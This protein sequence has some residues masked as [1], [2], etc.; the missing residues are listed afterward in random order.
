REPD[1]PRTL[2]PL[3]LRLDPRRDVAAF[4]AQR[5]DR[6]GGK[7]VVP[8][9][10]LEP[11]IAR[12]NR[13]DRAYVHQVARNQRMDAFFLER[14]DLAAVAAVDDVDLR[15]AVHVAHESHAPRAQDAALA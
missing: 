14:R 5:A 13:A 12:G 4:L 15:I 3:R 8:R 11:V 7:R 6:V 2:G 1:E 10:R 9:T